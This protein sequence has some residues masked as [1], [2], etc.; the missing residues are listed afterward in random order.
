MSTG[1]INPFSTRLPGQFPGQAPG[2]ILVRTARPG[3][4][5]S[6]ERNATERTARPD[7]S[8]A[9]NRPVPADTVSLS[10]QARGLAAAL[11]ESPEGTRSASDGP[12]SFQDPR[13]AASPVADGGRAESGTADKAE[14]ATRDRTVAA[15]TS[16]NGE[17]LSESEQRQVEQFKARDQEVKI[18]EEAHVAAAGALFRGG[19]NYTYTKGPDGV[20]YRTG[21][22]VQIDTSEGRTPEETIAKAQ[23]IVRAA[24]APAEPSSTDRAV[25]AKA[26]AQEADAR[27]ELAKEAAESSDEAPGTGR[28]TGSNDAP[29]PRLLVPSSQP[30]DQST[31]TDRI[32]ATPRS[33]DGARSAGDGPSSP[34]AAYTSGDLKLGRELSIYA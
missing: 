4:I 13:V 12:A 7:K 33:T 14:G 15:E 22:S 1:A 18:H 6:S 28:A 29:S 25:A 34:I 5:P 8:T 16:P 2:S 11:D 20:R 26:R 32:D 21:G 19:P 9:P 27:A 17:P 10:P 24:L 23:Q 31:G 3:S 30:D